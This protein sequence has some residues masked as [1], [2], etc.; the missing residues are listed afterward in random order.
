VRDRRRLAMDFAQV[1]AAGRASLGIVQVQG[2]RSAD[3]GRR[4]RL[5]ERTRERQRG[6]LREKHADRKQP[7]DRPTGGATKGHPCDRKVSSWTRFGSASVC[8]KLGAEHTGP[9][10]RAF[11]RHQRPAHRSKSR[12]ERRIDP[13]CLARSTAI[14]PWCR[15]DSRHTR[16]GTLVGEVAPTRAWYVPTSMKKLRIPLILLVAL[17]LP[18]KGAMAAAGMFC[19]LGSAQP[20]SAIVQ[21]HQHHAGAHQ[22]HAEHHAVDGDSQ[23]DAEDDAPLIPASSSCAICSAVCSAPPLP[24]NGIAFHVPAASGAECFP[25]LSPPRLS[26]VQSG[27][28]RP[29]RT[30]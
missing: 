30:I 29:P 4:R 25:A 27:L 1:A 26:A 6:R 9:A 28:E 11:D 2:T 22:N 5:V 20:M 16:A 12:P 3:V 19:H 17:I 24:A 14:T 13:A 15:A 18:V 10:A 8:P 23:S 21:P 7:G